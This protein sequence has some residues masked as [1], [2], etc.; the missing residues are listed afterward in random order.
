MDEITT[1][2][3]SLV[4]EYLADKGIAFQLIEHPY[5]HS[6]FA[7][8]R[9]THHRPESVGKTVVL[10]D[11]SGYVLAIVPAS[12]R[13]D[14]RKLRDALGTTRQLQLVN[15]AEMASEFPEFELGAI[16]P[17]GGILPAAEVVDHR[18]LDEDRILCGGGDHT[19]S[20]LIDPR[21]VVAVTG[22]L[23]ADVC[24]D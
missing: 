24:Q 10:C 2:G 22:A 23:V 7:D 3:S 19:H 11:R 15:E 16:P 17:F 6:A 5:T 18:L 9:A 4:T 21:D 20:V 8:A 1:T 13:L 14:L 12:E